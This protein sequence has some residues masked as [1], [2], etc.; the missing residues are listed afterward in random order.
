MGNL[1]AFLANLNQA[2]RNKETVTIGGGE[3]SGK[4]LEDLRDAVK[5]KIQDLQEPA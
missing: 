4:E 3:F 2:I 5:E 1:Q